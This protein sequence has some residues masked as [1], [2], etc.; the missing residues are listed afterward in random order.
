VS[1]RVGTPVQGEMLAGRYRLDECLAEYPRTHRTLWRGTD[2]VLNRQ[3]AVELRVPGGEGAA[4]FLATAITVSRIVHPAVIGVYD[5]VDEGARA[6]V[7]REWVRG[8]SLASEVRDTP[9]APERAVA[10]A[11][12][13]VEGIAALHAAGATHG[14]VNPNSVLIK[15][16]DSVTLT[17]LRPAEASTTADVR[18]VG[19]LLYAALTGRWPAEI[20][21]PPGLPDALRA[22]GKL[23]SP[24]QV[25]AGIPDYLDAVTMD[26]LDPTQPPPSAAE[27]ATELRRFDLDDSPEAD[28]Y[29]AEE[30]D[31][32]RR[33]SWTRW[34]LT[35]MSVFVVAIL[36][37][38]I[39]TSVLPA[40]GVG[41]YPSSAG[42]S[43]PNAGGSLQVFPAAGARILDP[44]GD[45][46]ELGG[47][48]LSIDGNMDTAWKTQDYTQPNFGGIK[49]GMGIRIDLGEAK[50]VRQVTVRLSASGASVQLRVGSG[51]EDP[52]AYRTV[53]SRQDAA[54][55]ITLRVPTGVSERYWLVWITSLPVLNDNGYSIGVREVVLAG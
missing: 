9:M 48:E 10:V 25:R 35:V 33:S 30:G 22:D 28:S 51:S 15:A 41:G 44:A 50:A 7:V 8:A 2:A 36:G 39:G 16:D 32:P 45:G 55:D 14:N 46:A 29:P 26:L 13:V 18:A 43:D 20:A 47:A 21:A 53:A 34:A 49:P 24:R 11:R 42:P 1:T 4:E 3:V 12:S 40:G 52:Q 17:D 54:E 23:C 31:E 6:Y 19:A 27:L 37:W 38:V 5:A